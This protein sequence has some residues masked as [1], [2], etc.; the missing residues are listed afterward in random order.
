MKKK[1][2]IPLV[3]FKD[4]Y[5]VQARGFT[6]HK[7][8][9]LLGSTLSRL[10]EWGADEILVVNISSGSTEPY[11]QVG[12]T[13]IMEDF[14]F[15]FIRAV[16]KHASRS[17]VPLTVGGGIREHAQASQ[18][19]EI[20]AD[21]ILINTLF[22]MDQ[23]LI[24]KL[25]G[26]FGSQAVVLGVDYKFLNGKREVFTTSGRSPVGQSVSG[27]ARIAA[28]LG[29]GEFFLNSIDRDGMKQGLDLEVA[30]EI[31][32]LDIPI[33]VCGGVG[34][35]E[36]ISEGLRID[37]VDGVAAANYFQH[38]ENS[39]QLARRSALNEGIV[40]RRLP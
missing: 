31:I 17:S 40:V 16:K 32:D 7:R 2:I 21:K 34:K 24:P 20:G 15:D 39:V 25:A 13:D 38:V 3:L 30:A 14:D 19:F 28:E 6:S 27:V 9:G 23:S 37:G 5:V 12:R 1:R 11:A 22:H 36:H 10:E 29:V 26:D 33:I 35:A 4:G 8:L 18:F